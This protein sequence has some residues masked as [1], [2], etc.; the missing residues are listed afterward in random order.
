MSDDCRKIDPGHARF[1]DNYVPTLPAGAYL[2]NVGQRVVPP[3]TPEDTECHVRS[4]AFVVAGPRYRLLDSDVFSVFPPPQAT[5]NFDSHLPHVVLSKEDL[6]WERKAFPDATA[7]TPWM[8]LLLFEAGEKFDGQ[9][10]L[11]PVG[12]SKS[13]TMSAPISARRFENPDRSGD[14]A[15]PEF[16]TQFYEE[17]V[18]DQT[19]VN[20]IDVSVPAFRALVPPASELPSLVHVRQVDPSV[21]ETEILRISK[22]GWY[23]VVVSRRFPRRD[24]SDAVVY[25]AHLVSLE[26]MRDYMAGRHLEGKK[27]VRMISLRGWTF[28]CAAHLTED[29]TQTMSGLLRRQR[30]T[31]APVTFS[32]PSD[33][34]A[35]S[36]DS[37]YAHAVMQQGF[38]PMRYQTRQGEE[39][40]AWYR[41]PFSPVPAKKFVVPPENESRDWLFFDRA[42]A[43][44]IYDPLYGVFDLTYAAAWEAGRLAALANGPFTQAVLEWQRR[45]THRVAV[46]TER[47]R[48]F[49][50]LNSR[51]LLRGASAAAGGLLG[52][53]LG[54]LRESSG[55]RAI[56]NELIAALI[57]GFND[58]LKPRSLAR[59]RASKKMRGARAAEESFFDRREAAVTPQAAARTLLADG[60]VRR[61]LR[62]ESTP[63]LDPIVDFLA[64]LYVLEHVPSAYL[65]PHPALLP[66]DSVRFF[67]IDANWLDAAMEG[68]LS[69]GVESSRDA[70][71]QQLMKDA[72]RAAVRKATKQIRQRIPAT[73]SEPLRSD[74][75]N[76]VEP[77]RMTGMLLRSPLVSGWRGLEVH[78]YAAIHPVKP[79]ELLRPNLNSWIQPLRIDRLSNDVLLCI[80]GDV[81]AV[82]TIDEPHEGVA[83][84][85][86]D[87]PKGESADG[88]Y[89]YLRHLSGDSFGTVIPGKFINA[90][91]LIDG[92]SQLNIAELQK[93]MRSKLNVTKLPPREFALQMVRVPQQGVF[94][95][96][97]GVLAGG[98]KATAAVKAKKLKRTK[99]KAKA[100]A[101]TERRVKAGG[102]RG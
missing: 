100:K 74:G 6:P 45:G 59:L 88:Y 64:Q 48:Q 35:D 28:T 92:H 7:P 90:K 91:D 14:L 102:R 97:T 68:A 5:G 86:Q 47:Q 44:M 99:I 29:F 55:E 17:E 22:R 8:A 19:K 2:I 31:G 50:L 85:F 71:Y 52:M 21:K 76:T 98:V 63:A 16:Q 77:T 36:R 80:W 11:L 66:R 15:W 54:Q 79:G 30:Q 95:W 33:P 10:A 27:A 9:E 42:S 83:F 81:P 34:P 25:I 39:T 61:L 37:Q 56:G 46:M 84:G 24:P 13:A 23:S 51:T 3:G 89:I 82:V 72:I 69:V 101:S 60:N 75:G 43:A 26:G 58:A 4:Q 41:G 87:A 12:N 49:R 94:A 65:V 62:Q 70:A 32:L 73:D 18:L 93:A 57:E 40:F 67:H 78:A 38:V 20:V 1:Y 53:N 96:K